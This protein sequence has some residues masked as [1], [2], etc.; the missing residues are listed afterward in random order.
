MRG[1]TLEFGKLKEVD[2]RELW[3]H[4]QYNFSEWLAKEE[5]IEMLGDEV[6]VTFS[7]IRKEVF[8]GA[9][10]CD[11]VAQ[12]ETSGAKIIIENQLEA[13]NHDHLGKII[14]YASGLEARLLFGL[15]RKLAKNTA[16]QSSG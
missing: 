16:V 12:D 9:Y 5:N 10:R 4:E 13:T 7:E 1:I 6:G 8:V 14:T 11:V 2:V 15:L 3:K